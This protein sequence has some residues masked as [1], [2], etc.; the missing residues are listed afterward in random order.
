[1]CCFSIYLALL[2]IFILCL[3]PRRWPQP[4]FR[5]SKVTDWL[6]LRL[7]FRRFTCAK[8]GIPSDTT[9][10]F[11]HVKIC[12]KA[13]LVHGT[14]N[15]VIPRYTAGCLC[16]GMYR[17]VLQEPFCNIYI[18]IVRNIAQRGPVSTSTFRDCYRSVLCVVNKRVT[19]KKVATTVRTAVYQ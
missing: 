16:I 15:A 12:L 5:A 18:Y 3:Y 1:M 7:R 2:F 10:H 9:A 11:T 4:R 14:S 17:Q 6:W 19:E 8:R 13:R